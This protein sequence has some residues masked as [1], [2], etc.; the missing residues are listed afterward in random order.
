MS[1]IIWVLRAYECTKRQVTALGL[2]VYMPQTDPTEK[3]VNECTDRLGIPC[4]R[5]TDRGS[6]APR[7]KRKRLKKKKSVCVGN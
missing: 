5:M 7:S 6:F 1:A 3:V 4:F 2:W